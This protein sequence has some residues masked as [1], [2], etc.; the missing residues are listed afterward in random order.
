M[1]APR[2]ALPALALLALAGCGGGHAAREQP[3]PPTAVMVAPAPEPVP[4]P[5]P[6]PENAPSASAAASEAA[7]GTQLPPSAFVCLPS[8]EYR[9]GRKADAR[10]DA[11]LRAA[12]AAAAAAP[13]PPVVLPPPPETR[14]PASGKLGSILGRKVVGTEGDDMGRVVDVLADQGGRA[15]AAV[16]DFGGFLGVG[17]RRVAVDWRL[18]QFVPD[19]PD[20]PLLLSLSRQQ[21]QAAPEF[22][23]AAHTE[24]E[25]VTPPAGSSGH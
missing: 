8:E 1:S 17:N 13:P 24:Q 7:A 6:I 11:A 15:R 3:A 9:A 4:E 18:L 19:D 23:D 21:V 14:P 16:I 5:A 25:I 10:R 22:K 12:L 2:L 20:K